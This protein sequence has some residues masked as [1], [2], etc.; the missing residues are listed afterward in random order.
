[1]YSY[2]I[3]F[4]LIDDF[5]AELAIPT[6]RAYISTNWVRVKGGVYTYTGVQPRYVQNRT[7]C[8]VTIYGCVTSGRLW[9]F[10]KLEGD[11][12]PSRPR[13]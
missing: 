1:M 5:P 13:S 8:K 9:Q 4:E 6:L 10:L 3:P 12:E 11:L 7:R 2:S